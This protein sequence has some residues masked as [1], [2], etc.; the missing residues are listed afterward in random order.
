MQCHARKM[1]ALTGGVKQNASTRE[2]GRQ[3]SKP[4]TS[5][6]RRV[7]GRSSCFEAVVLA[8]LCRASETIKC[9]TA[10][11]SGTVKITRSGTRARRSS[12]LL[13]ELPTMQSDGTSQLVQSN[14]PRKENT[15]TQSNH[16]GGIPTEYVLSREA[17]TC[18]KVTETLNLE[19]KP[20]L[21]EN[22]FTSKT[23]L[24]RGIA[25]RSQPGECCSC[26]TY[27]PSAATLANINKTIRIT[28]S[29]PALGQL[30]HTSS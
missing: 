26:N 22:V 14:S 9:T 21:C 29:P 2:T 11:T 16:A 17:I 25:S 30:S 20:T 19:S 8:D 12:W 4:C 6:A 18:M 27:T 28:R 3:S 5:N 10:P 13:I 1:L 7:W 23:N 24:R 15:F